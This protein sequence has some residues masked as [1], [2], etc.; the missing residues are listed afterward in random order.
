MLSTREKVNTQKRD[1][2]GAQPE[3]PPLQGWAEELLSPEGGCDS[4]TKS[5]RREIRQGRRGGSYRAQEEGC[6]DPVT[7]G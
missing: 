5:S 1:G 2:P 7:V 6:G 4:H 3:V